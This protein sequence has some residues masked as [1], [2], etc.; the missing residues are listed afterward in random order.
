MKK[1]TITTKT[2]SLV[3]AGTILLSSCASTTMIQSTP[4]GA[5]VYLNFNAGAK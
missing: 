3:L 2:V 4:S 5:K 1:Q